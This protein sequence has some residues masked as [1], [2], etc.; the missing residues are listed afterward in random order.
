APTQWIIEDGIREH[1]EEKPA[2]LTVHTSGIDETA[3]Q[4]VHQRVSQFWRPLAEK[5]GL[6][7]HPF[8]GGIELRVRGVDK[9]SAVDTILEEMGRDAAAAYAGDDLTDEDAFRAIKG[10]GLGILARKEFR[11]TAA[12]LWLKP[13]EEL[14]EFLNAW[15]VVS[16]G[17]Q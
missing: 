10:R 8:S 17:A 5:I 7:V 2:S 4:E 1:L 6:E 16:G 14:L 15:L 12:D 11:S 9:G 3:E 13:P